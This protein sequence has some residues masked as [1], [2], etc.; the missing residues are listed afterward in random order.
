MYLDEGLDV[1]RIHGAWLDCGTPLSL[2]KANATLLKDY[3][4]INS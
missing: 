4:E 2:A 3:K 1:K